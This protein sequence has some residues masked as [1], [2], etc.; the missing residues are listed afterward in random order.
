MSEEDSAMPDAFTFTPPP[1]APP[2]PH[3]AARVFNAVKGA[4]GHASA[5]QGTPPAGQGT[6]PA[7]QGTAPAG[8]GSRSRTHGHRSSGAHGA[9]PPQ[10]PTGHGPP[11]SPDDEPPAGNK[12]RRTDNGP[13]PTPRKK[14]RSQASPTAKSKDGKTTGR[15]GWHIPQSKV[16]KSAKGLKKALQLHI[17]ITIGVLSHTAVPTLAASDMAAFEKRYASEDDLRAQLDNIIDHAIPPTD[18]AYARI[19]EYLKTIT[20]SNSQNS[21][22]A[23]RLGQNHLRVIF[24]GIAN[25]G[26]TAFAPDILGNEESMYN[27]IH[28]H[29][30]IHTFCTLATAHAYVDFGVKLP[31]LKEYHLL[32]SF[33]RSFVYGLFR[34]QVR[35]EA[36]TPGRV[37]VLSTKNNVYRRR[38]DLCNDRL[39]QIKDD[40]FAQPVRRLAKENSCHSDDDGPT[41]DSD[42]YLIHK[43]P[44]RDD[45]VTAFFRIIDGRRNA[46]KQHGMKGRWSGRNRVTG[47]DA[48][49]TSLR[50]PKKVPIDYFSP[51]FFNSM[52]VRQRA[53]YMH[54]GIAL[55]TIEN[56][57]TWEKILEWKGLDDATFMK[58]YGK[59]KLALYNVPTEAELA[60]LDESDDEEDEEDEEDD[61]E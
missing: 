10:P 15:K 24:N 52:S 27:L 59:A 8:Q 45:L 40:C 44:G 54:N 19:S 51:E 53:S 35:Q 36:Q 1:N 48:S 28:E 7:G 56:C 22:D 25:A 57:D 38:I 39:K 47:I 4:F 55:P 14:S 42:E 16:A 21:R 17:R 33:Y 32:R 31:L 60:R 11:P 50:L 3:A 49:D 13:E 12:R 5:G 30:A 20:A 61:D 43:K 37:E 9:A 34:K 29:L 41:G 46:T 26:L 18:A 23:A 2:Y 6:A 58:K